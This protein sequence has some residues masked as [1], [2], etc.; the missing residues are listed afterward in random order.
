MY[1]KMMEL[2]HEFS[3]ALSL[4]AIN[5][6]LLRGYTSPSLLSDPLAVLMSLLQSLSSLNG[7][8]IPKLAPFPLALTSQ[9]YATREQ[10]RLNIVMFSF[11]L[12][13]AMRHSDGS[14]VT[15]CVGPPQI[16]IIFAC[17]SLSFGIVFGLCL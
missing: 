9:P 4:M 3:A 11:F 8:D 2:L 15:I 14:L 12:S 17:V 10:G 13:L 7:S 1:R 16:V 5:E 6:I